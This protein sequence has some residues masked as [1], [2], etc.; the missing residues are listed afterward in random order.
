MREITTRVDIDASPAAVW[1]V[2]TDF[3]AYP[4][5]NPFMTVEGHPRKGERLTV[6]LSPP[7][8]RSVTFR[9]VVRRADGD[10]LRWEGR[11]FVPGLYDG[12]HRFALTEHPDGTTTLVHD[13]TFG[14]VLVGPINRRF[15]PAVERGFEEMNAAL[16][17]RVEAQSEAVA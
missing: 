2:L 6:H 3:A 8:G 9:P 1:R 12:T 11:L 13:E 4:E 14:G 15:G 16:K 7:G 10:E 17:A 5:W